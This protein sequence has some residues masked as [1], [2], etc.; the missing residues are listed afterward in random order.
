[1]PTLKESYNSAPV[2]GGYAVY[3]SLAQ[4]AQVFQASGSYQLSQ[5]KIQLW[6][7][8]AS[9]EVDNVI[10]DLKAVDG[11][12]KPTGAALSTGSVLRSTLTESTPGTMI[13]FTMS[14]YNLVSGTKYAIVPR[15]PDTAWGW[16]VLWAYGTT[17]AYTEK[18]WGSSDG[19]S[20]W[21]EN[22]GE[23]FLFE[24]Y[25]SAVTF[26]TDAITR[27]TGL[28]HRYDRRQGVYELEMSMGDTTSVLQRPY[29]G[30][31]QRATAKAQDEIEA[32]PIIKKAVETTKQEISRENLSLPRIGTD[33][34]LKLMLGLVKKPKETFDI[35]TYEDLQ[36]ELSKKKIP[37]QPKI[38]T[39]DYLKKMLGLK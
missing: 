8:D 7:V 9:G 14:A 36:K 20:T 27:V 38:G 23:Y 25:S 13:T 31:P 19:G 16:Q 5:I 29:A 2:I 26:P 12:D 11:A 37:T 39:I 34:Y 32:A 6:T 4:R 17:P 24:G 30:S 21:S 22:V 10:V 3:E 15:S 33:E 28:T 18:G 35:K 1:M